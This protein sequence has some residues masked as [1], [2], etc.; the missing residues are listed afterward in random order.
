MTLF[1]K[2]FEVAAK[3]DRLGV[4]LTRVGLVVVLVW[5]GALKVYH[6]EADGIVPFVANSPFVSF[7]YGEP[8]DYKAHTNPEGAVVAAN[9]AWH[10]MNRTYPFAL[11]LGAVIRAHWRPR[12][13]D[14]RAPAQA[15]FYLPVNGGAH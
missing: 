12:R 14:H 9:R 13:G 4:T 11:G 7:F 10:E 8:H 5:S 3:L 2:L 15:R 6:Y 1:N